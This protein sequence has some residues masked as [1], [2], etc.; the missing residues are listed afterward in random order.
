MKKLT[1]YTSYKDAQTYCNKKTLW[2]LMAGNEDNFNI[3]YECVDRHATNKEKLA[4][5]VVQSDGSEE[6]ITFQQLSIASSRFAHYLNDIGI[7]KGDRI[8]RSEERRV[9]K[10]SQS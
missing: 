7:K 6:L 5:T 4:I 8:A 3:S 9:G 1:D 2:A 10:R